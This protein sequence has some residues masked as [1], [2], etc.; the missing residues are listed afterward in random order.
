[1]SFITFYMRS[2]L[3]ACLSP[4]FVVVV[5]SW[6]DSFMMESDGRTDGRTEVCKQL[7]TVWKKDSRHRR[8]ERTRVTP[9]SAIDQWH[10]T[11]ISTFFRLDPWIFVCFF[12]SSNSKEN[13]LFMSRFRIHLCIPD[14]NKLYSAII[15]NLN[16]RIM[17]QMMSHK[18]FWALSK[19]LLIPIDSNMR[20][21]QQQQK[22]CEKLMQ[23][24]S[25]FG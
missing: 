1:M 23:R 15:L 5:V 25:Q 18:P 6:N 3:S 24:R 13:P 10:Q 22:N 17:S 21:N 20:S 14:S 12:F 11:T 16:Q 4:L 9:K 2:W 8:S 19:I 7:T